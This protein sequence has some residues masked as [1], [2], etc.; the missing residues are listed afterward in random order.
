LRSNTIA[1]F[2]L[3]EKLEKQKAKSV[4][5]VAVEDVS[6]YIGRYDFGQMIMTITTEGNN[7]FAQLSGQ[8]S[9]PIFPA[10]DGEYFWKVVN[11]KIKFVKGENGEIQYGDFEQNG[12]KIKVVKLKDDK[13][14]SIDKSFYKLYSGRYQ[15][16]P[17]FIVAITSENDKLYAQATNQPRFEILPLSEKEFTLKEVNAKLIFVT[18]S[19]GKVS[20]FI[21]D[22]G[23][24][25]QDLVRLTD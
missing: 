12:N 14:V 24:L 18:D 16:N 5:T 20:K 3:Y 7:L 4:N 19:N 23:G 9:F 10:G 1:E 15:L 2:I 13:V 6:K 25:K 17:N 22:Q 8:P 21:L 11:A